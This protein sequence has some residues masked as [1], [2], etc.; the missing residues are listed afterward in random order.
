MGSKLHKN[1][2]H[3]KV[4]VCVTRSTTSLNSPRSSIFVGI[5]LSTSS[6]EHDDDEMETSTE[7]PDSA[8]RGILKKNGTAKKKSGRRLR[9]DS[10]C[11]WSELNL[12]PFE[13]I[14]N[15]SL[16]TVVK[17]KFPGIGSTDCILFYQVENSDGGS[18]YYPFRIDRPARYSIVSVYERIKQGLFWK[19]VVCMAYPNNFSF[20]QL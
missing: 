17:R 20:L 8:P 2:C 10:T 4:H 14:S 5:A 13:E 1:W 11:K 9:F 12:Q 7:I 19:E 6:F 15:S 18:P 3:Y 16:R